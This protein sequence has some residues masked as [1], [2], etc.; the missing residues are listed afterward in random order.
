MLWSIYKTS[1]DN[2]GAIA[3]SLA[4]RRP[5]CPEFTPV[6]P[7]DACSSGT[8]LTDCQS[9]R[10][11]SS[12]CVYWFTIYS[13][14]IRQSTSATCWPSL[15]TGRPSVWSSSCGYFIVPRTIRKFG[16]ITF[17]VAAPRAWNRLPIELGQLRSTPLFKC[18]LKTFLF[19]AEF[20]NWTVN[21]NELCNAPSVG[22]RW[23]TRNA[24]CIVLY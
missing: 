11:S 9:R 3:A 16:Y 14:A 17:S 12:S 24:V 10:G 5:T 19:T 20:Q 18:K 2:T 21:W 8:A 4:H 23:R 22:C 1:S 13:S 7:H 15:L 6:W